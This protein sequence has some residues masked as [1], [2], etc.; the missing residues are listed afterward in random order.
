M[1]AIQL[2][3]SV[4]RPR[5]KELVSALALG[6]AFVSLSSGLAAPA[7]A[8]E[9]NASLRGTVTVE[10][11]ATQVAAI[12]VNSGIRRTAIVAPDGSYNFPSLRP[13]TYRLE[14]TT[15][16]GVRRTD[17]ITLTVA[18]NAQLDIDLTAQQPPVTAAPGEPPSDTDI[19][20]VGQRIR[21]MEGGEV[22]ANI[23]QRLIQTLPQNNRNFLAF[24]D[25]APGV[26]FIQADNGQARLQGGA[27]DSRTVNIFIDG[28]GQKDYVLKNGI[29]GQDSTQ[30]NP[31]PQSAIGEYR[32]ISSNYKAEFDQVSSV[33][34]TAVTKSGTNEFHGSGFVD[35][36][37]QDL[38]AKRP[39]EKGGEKVKTKDFQ[40]G[41]SLGGP[42]IKD[43]MHFFVAYEGKRREQPRDVTPGASRDPEDFPAEYQDLFGPFAVTFSEDLYFAKV[44][45]SP[46]D[47]DLIELSG[48][49]RKETGEELN[50]G[51]QAQS[52][53]LDINNDEKRGL[54]RW[55]HTEDQWINDLKIA[56]ENAS[57]APTPQNFENGLIFQSDAPQRTELLSI[58]GAPSFQDKGQKGWTFQNDFTWIGFENHTIKAGVKAKWVKL[59]A[60]QLNNTNAQYTFNADFGGGFNDETPYRVIFGAPTGVGTPDVKSDNFQFGIYIQDDWDVTDRLT[61]NL[62]IRWDYERTPAYLNYETPADAIAAVGPANYPNLINADYDIN[63]FISTG[64]E[65]EAFKGAFQPRIGFSYDLDAEGRFVLFGGYGRSYDRNQFD[66]LQLEI[67]QPSFRTREFRFITGD[68]GNDCAPVSSTCV[69][70]DPIYF[71]PEGRALLL[72]GTPGGRGG[73]E[74]FFIDNDLKVPRSDQFSLGVRGR[75][76]SLWQAE[77]GYSYV[78]GKNGFGWLL[79]NRRPDGSFFP[80]NAPPDSPFCCAP[81]GFG[82]IL[83]GTNGI[84]TKAHSVYLKGTKVYSPSSPWSLDATYTHMRAREN[85]QFG[86]TFSLDYPSFDDYPFA[87]SSGVRRHRLVAAG[88]VDLPRPF[89]ATVSGKLTVASPPYVKGFVNQQSAPFER[90][91]EAT[92]AETWLAQLDLAVTKYFQ[93]P[94]LSDDSEIWFRV[95]VFNVLNRKNWNVFESCPC[96]ANFGERIGLDVGG[97]PPRTFKLSAGFSF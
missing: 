65:R 18:Q 85:R 28:I 5:V 78:I 94:M 31:F 10:G 12:D 89:D 45:F 72:A 35:F 87:A 50:S 67:S 71:T 96:S 69:P 88:S 6:A 55:E 40:Y 68:P 60:L 41:I 17:E 54:L 70:W 62:G 46:T 21:S 58:G 49:Y 86:E 81:P 53:M 44:D 97:N 24:A 93:L 91:V 56:Y 32:V 2:N 47:N 64:S 63:D 25:L 20:V 11:G 48:K 9:V 76:T 52:R 39:S 79:G 4:R 23:S 3:K 37:N 19:V 22:G 77:V 95:D 14:I 42:I 90:L 43:K 92:E 73:G 80:P 59:H 57:W 13:G 33:A 8:Q 84:E 66:F 29:T 15:P 34:I 82:A 83:L 7:H 16:A 51:Q 74:L 61:L 75:L 38:R 1:K 30:G 36:T 27:Q 26:S